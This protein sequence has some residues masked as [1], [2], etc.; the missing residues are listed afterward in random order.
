[1]MIH[2]LLPA[3][4]ANGPG[5]RFVLWTQGCSRRCPGCFNPGAQ[6]KKIPA[7]ELSVSRIISNIPSGRVSGIT[8][9]GGEPFEQPEELLRLLAAARGLGLHTL[10]Y[11][12]F[13]YEELR[14]TA[15][16]I[17]RE[18]DMLIDG[19]YLREIPPLSPW[20]GSGNQRLLRLREG[21]VLSRDNG[22]S[23]QAVPFVEGEIFIDSRGLITETGI[24]SLTT[25]AAQTV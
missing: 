11:S 16:E 17:L 14:R 24:F 8:V 15:R 2:S 25:G 20:T 12:G 7:G 19:P 21:E 5:E 18:I 22:F 10:V 13:T 9:S 4:R 1:M 3:S 6:A 23:P